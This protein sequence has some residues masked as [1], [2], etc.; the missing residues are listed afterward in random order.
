MSYFWKAMELLLA[1]EPLVSP[2]REVSQTKTAGRKVSKQMEVS[3]V[4]VAS[5]SR[6]RRSG[7]AVK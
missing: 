4:T 5:V 1:V 6:R 2:Q 3:T 7:I